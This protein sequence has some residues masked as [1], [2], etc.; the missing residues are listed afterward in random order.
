MGH[1]ILI[2]DD[3][4]FIRDLYLEVLK[5]ASFDVDIAVDG[6]EALDK[7]LASQYDLILLDIV[8]P[9]KDGM[10]VL[11]SLQLSGKKNGVI[12][13][14]TNLAHDP[15]LNDALRKGAASYFIKTDITPD[16]VVALVKK[17]LV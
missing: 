8:M 14:A 7:L 6:Q 9:K 12:I 2:A 5:D 17:Y 3:D 16:E 1:R 15:I 10:E 11:T 4:A 13:V